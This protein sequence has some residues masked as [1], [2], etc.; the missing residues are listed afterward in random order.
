MSMNRRVASEPELH[1]IATDRYDM[2]V[3]SGW[4]LSL[5]RTCLAAQRQQSG[6]RMAPSC[7]IICYGLD[8]GYRVVLDIEVYLISGID[9][10]L[11]W[12]GLL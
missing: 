4:H 2:R 10:A 7:S 9:A 11:P 12:H 5:S 1:V 6:M 8:I 3:I